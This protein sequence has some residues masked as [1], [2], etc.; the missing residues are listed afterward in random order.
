MPELL[1]FQV[2]SPVPPEARA[3]QLQKS[4]YFKRTEKLSSE[5]T[6]LKIIEVSSHAFELGYLQ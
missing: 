2:Q 6:V 4:I 3:K 5:S 1:T